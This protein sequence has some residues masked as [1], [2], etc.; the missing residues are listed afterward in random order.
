M[1]FILN[2]QNGNQ[3][4]VRISEGLTENIGFTFLGEAGTKKT[5][6]KFLTSDPEV[7]RERQMLFYDLL[8]T[9]ELVEFIGT[10]AEK[11]E[12]I[13]QLESEKPSLRNRGTN[14]SMFS[15]FRE[16]L[17]F[18]ECIDFI[19]ENEKGFRG[20]V[21]ADG[22]HTLFDKAREIAGAEW[23]QSAKLYIEKMC[24]EIKDIQSVTIGINLDAQLG[25]LEAGI[26]SV[27]PKKF[28]TNTLLDKMFAKNISEKDYICIAPIAAREL[29][30]S[31]VSMQIF[32]GRLYAAMS[33][34]V[35]K[36]LKKIK[37]YLYDNL[38]SNTYFL[39]DSYDELKFIATCAHYLLSMKA[40]GMPLCLPEISDHYKIEGL[41]NPNLVGT[42]PA[43]NIVKNDVSFDEN[44]KIFI[45]TGANSGGKSIYLRSVGIA[46]ILFQLGL[47]IPA[48][49]ADMEICSEIFSLFSSKVSDTHGGRFE[50]ECKGLLEFYKE[51]TE[52]SL[53]LLDEMFASTSSFE[54]TIVAARVLK[55]FA[56]TGC[57]CIYTTHMHDLIS[58]IEAINAEPNIK[59][60]VDGL[61]AEMIN[62]T[63]TYKIKRCRESYYGYAEEICKKYGF[64]F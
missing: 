23:Y 36:S 15:S 2:F 8:E 63:A 57:K 10:L 26:V 56:Q 42:V 30:N 31:G 7:I 64:D 5:I 38:S 59:S 62:R 32:N 34:I 41:Y 28:T 58:E 60:R 13:I 52:N 24:E 29:R 27:N 4:P 6:E 14:E 3:H 40:A 46:Q 16:L 1:S 9:E 11:I 49:N 48:R 20:K 53:I 19:L 22:I 35:G 50:N 39:L 25:V 47:P 61:S 55:Y 44:G 12:L 45:L 18:I 37:Q 51:T 21:K 17:S 33:E 43:V 54:G